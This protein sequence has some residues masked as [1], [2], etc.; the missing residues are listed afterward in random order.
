MTGN[1]AHTVTLTRNGQLLGTLA[2]PKGMW[3]SAVDDRQHP[4]RGPVL[5]GRY[6]FHGM[7]ELR[8]L[9]D[10]EVRG[11]REHGGVELMSHAPLVLSTQD[12]DV[13][14]DTDR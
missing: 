5:S 8:A 10:H 4:E 1:A 13:V 11:K 2:F 7:F 3:L 14:V 9:A 6:T 12:V